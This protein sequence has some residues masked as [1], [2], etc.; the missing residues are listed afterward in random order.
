MRIGGRKWASEVGL[1]IGVDEGFVGDS[2]CAA[3]KER[4]VDGPRLLRQSTH[5]L[6]GS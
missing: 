2:G 5:Y 4:T 1:V 6:L 3:D